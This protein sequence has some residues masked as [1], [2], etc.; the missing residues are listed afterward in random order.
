M[1][2]KIGTNPFALNRDRDLAA[3]ARLQPGKSVWTGTGWEV[4]KASSVERVTPGSHASADDAERLLRADLD[5]ARAE[6]AAAEEK[7]YLTSAHGMDPG[8]AGRAR[9]EE[10][11]SKARDLEK[12]LSD[13]RAFV[14]QDVSLHGAREQDSQQKLEALA[15]R[16]AAL[17]KQ[18]REASA[19]SKTKAK[20]RLR[21]ALS[22][23]R[24]ELGVYRS[25]RPPKGQADVRVAIEPAR[26]DEESLA[27]EKSRK[28]LAESKVKLKQKLTS[29]KN[30]K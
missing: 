27:R 22:L 24:E 16:R 1:S 5:R 7:Y 23:F 15:A 9:L 30:A 17:L 21:D 20:A 10:A 19:S 28:D 26:H 11:Q 18:A 25:A 2:T 12:R 8:R 6:L 4:R 13:L 29:K 14:E 3:L